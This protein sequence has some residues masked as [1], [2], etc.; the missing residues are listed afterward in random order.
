MTTTTDTTERTYN[1]WTNYETW[2]VNLW[3]DNDE[4]SYRYWREAAREHLD[5]ADGDKDSAT[6]GL[7]LRLREEVTDA[8]PDMGASLAADLLGAAMSEV[9]WHEIAVSMFDALD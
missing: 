1:G 3:L 7:S 6:G 9:D 5:G 8:Q 2:A 4:G